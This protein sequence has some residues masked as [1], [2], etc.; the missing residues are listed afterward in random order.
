MQIRSSEAGRLLCLGRR[1][2]IRNSRPQQNRN[3]SPA[4]SRV[5]QGG[6][7]LTSSPPGKDAISEDNGVTSAGSYLAE[8]L[9]LALKKD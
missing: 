2:N 9:T 8:F 1:A 3:L 6:L 5:H 4:S 7:P